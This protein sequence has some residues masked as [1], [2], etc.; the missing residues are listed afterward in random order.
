MKKTIPNKPIR[1]VINSHNHFDHSGGLRACVAEG[2]TILTS[3]DNKPYYEKVW[4]M[5]HT[6]NPD[7]LA[8]APKKPVVEAVA[9]KRVLT[10]GTQILELYHLQGS[11]H[12]PIR[13]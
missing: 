13:C 4:A 11:N 3:T 12:T 9:D 1:Y 10:D 6:L 8:K 5:P 7:R 2:A